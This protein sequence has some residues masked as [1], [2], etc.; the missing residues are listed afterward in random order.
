MPDPESAE[1]SVT[2]APLRTRDRLLR[3][4]YFVLGLVC[5]ALGVIGAFVPLMPSTIFLILAAWAFARSSTRL[6]AWL[7]QHRQFGPVLQ[8]WRRERV[9]PRRAKWLACLGMTV[10]LL[11]FVLGAHPE[12]WLLA[13]VTLLLLGCAAY[14]ASRPEPRL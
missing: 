9:I 1:V 4:V 2:P 8:A 11:L 5:V 6:E 7:M 13:V 12:P 3:P 10:G 14:V